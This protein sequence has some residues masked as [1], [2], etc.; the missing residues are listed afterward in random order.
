MLGLGAECVPADPPFN[1]S[2]PGGR[3]LKEGGRRQLG[4]A[5][6]FEIVI[7][8]NLEVLGYGE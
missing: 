1:F 4:K 8:K 3:R 2:D 6:S 7:A 5:R